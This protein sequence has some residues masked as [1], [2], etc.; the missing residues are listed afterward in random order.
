MV[1][2]RES[3]TCQAILGEG[4]IEGGPRILIRLATKTMGRLDSAT[5]ATIETIRDFDRLCL[6]RELILDS[7][8]RDWGE[9]LRTA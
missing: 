6:M 4:R 5:L 7:H 8:V 3:T 9:L 1:D 2:M